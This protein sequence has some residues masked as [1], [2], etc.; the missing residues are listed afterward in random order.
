ML[1]SK[2]SLT[3]LKPSLRNVKKKVMARM[4]KINADDAEM[5]SSTTA[6]YGSFKNSKIRGGLAHTEP[7]LQVLCNILHTCALNQYR[8]LRPAPRA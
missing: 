8:S 2:R 7:A 1:I 3:D 6:T 5:P 4:H